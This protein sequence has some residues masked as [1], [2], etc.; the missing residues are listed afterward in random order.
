MLALCYA[1]NDCLYRWAKAMNLANSTVSQIFSLPGFLV[2][3]V[4]IAGFSQP[5]GKFQNVPVLQR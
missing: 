1:E 5:E 3:G 4:D 2:L